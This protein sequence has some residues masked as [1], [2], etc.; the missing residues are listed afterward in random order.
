MVSLASSY[1]IKISCEDKNKMPCEKCGRLCLKDMDCKRCT[2]YGSLHEA[3]VDHPQFKKS[4]VICRCQ[5]AE[6]DDEEEEEELVPAKP[7]KKGR[8][9]WIF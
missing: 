4:C 5:Q 2:Y 6:H 9:F 8:W 7:E 1:A 3:G